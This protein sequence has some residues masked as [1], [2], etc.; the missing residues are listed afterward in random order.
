MASNKRIANIVKKSDINITELTVKE[1]LLEEG[2]EQKL[3][4]SLVNAKT[5]NAQSYSEHLEILSNLKDPI[6]TFFDN[7]MVNSEDEAT[8]QNRILLLSS[9]RNEFLSI[10]DF[11]L[12]QG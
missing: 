5:A 6:D 11:S 9:I 12:L 7:V 4:D 8:R 10:A 3:F 1:D 2:A